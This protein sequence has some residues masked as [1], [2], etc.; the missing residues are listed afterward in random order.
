MLL[1]SGGVAPLRD[2]P[3]TRSTEAPHRMWGHYRRRLPFITLPFITSN[4]LLNHILP[5][6]LQAPGSACSLRPHRH[7]PPSTGKLRGRAAERPCR[8]HASLPRCARSAPSP[9]GGGGAGIP[10][11]GVPDPSVI[12]CPGVRGGTPRACESGPDRYRRL[13]LRFRQA[14]E[15]CPQRCVRHVPRDS[16]PAPRP[17]RSRS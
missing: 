9:P 17:P 15:R 3:T 10:C 4:Y 11:T 13:P 8:P 6:R 14:P 7:R 5:Q 12:R 1:T 16:V 2:H